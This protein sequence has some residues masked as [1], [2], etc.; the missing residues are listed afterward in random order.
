V[1]SEPAV[2]SGP[3]RMAT[4]SAGLRRS[5]TG[6]AFL[7]F[8]HEALLYDS[9]ESFTE[10]ALSFVRDGLDY[11]EPVLVALTNAKTAL[12]RDALG[13]D[14]LHV[15]FTDMEKLGH[16][17]GRMI[18]AW[19]AFA[20]GH[21]HGRAPL[22]ALAEP[23]WDGRSAE[24][25][26]EAERHEALVNVAFRDISRFWLL[27]PYD[28]TALEPRHIEAAFVCHPYIAYEHVEWRSRTYRAKCD[29]LA[30]DLA[31]PVTQPAELRFSGERSLA[32][33]RHLVVHRS[34]ALGLSPWRADGLL[35]AVN[36]AVVN[37]MRHGSGQGVLRMWST[38]GSVVCEVRDGG[39]ITDPLVG[40]KLPPG[41]AEGGRG[42]WLV[43]QL[44][45]LVQLRSS[46]RGTVVR[47]S[48]DLD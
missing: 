13:A 35:V 14:A 6:R 47:M 32:E 5:R 25:V 23:I 43:H 2:A 3:D 18:Q 33:A 31:E 11:G 42:L 17:P 48:M 15:F 30:G 29:P 37:S 26:A 10:G 12:L 21:A 36:E 46:E 9:N 27:C 41:D 44:C 19:W 4:R 22:R 8:R 24:E 40:Q 34:H 28:T 38:S 20:S 16:N 39:W 45:D 7:G 1:T